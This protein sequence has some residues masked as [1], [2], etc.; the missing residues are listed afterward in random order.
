VTPSGTTAPPARRNAIALLIAP[1]AIVMAGALVAMRLHFQPPNVPRYDA[2]VTQTLV[3]PGPPGAANDRGLRRGDRLSI[4]LH[5]QA[6][7]TGAIGAR[8]FLLRG[9][10]VRAADPP[11][12]VAVDGVVHI[13][14]T[15]DELFPDAPRGRWEVAVAVGRPE[16]LP[17]APRDVLRRR[18]EDPALAGWHL[19]RTPI[20]LEE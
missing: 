11:V 7:I 10:E 4:D 12:S 14:G 15:V 13:A 19:V 17:T 5:P 3:E 20:R 9:D 6:A 16:V 2:T 18:D 8:A 1:T